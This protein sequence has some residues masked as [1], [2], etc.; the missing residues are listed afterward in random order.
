MAI[1]TQLDTAGDG[2]NDEGREHAQEGQDI[3]DE[4]EAGIS[5]VRIV[6]DGSEETRDES[7]TCHD[8]HALDDVVQKGK[9]SEGEHA[10]PHSI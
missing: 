9:H 10:H 2:P 6:G 8:D 5:L 1:F 7:H 4:L 3:E